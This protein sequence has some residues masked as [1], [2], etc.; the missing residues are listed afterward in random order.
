[1]FAAVITKCSRTSMF[2][3]NSHTV[4]NT[5]ANTSSLY[6]VRPYVQGKPSE[7]ITI[8]YIYGNKPQYT[9]YTLGLSADGMPIPLHYRCQT[10][11][12]NSTSGLPFLLPKKTVTRRMAPLVTH[13]KISNTETVQR[14]CISKSKQTRNDELYIVIMTNIYCEVNMV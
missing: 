10:A 5:L 12:C 2:V 4:R 8:C 1:M 11:L 9:G 3:N 14:N 7:L 13:N 6:T